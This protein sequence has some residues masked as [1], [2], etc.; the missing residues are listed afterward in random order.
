MYWHLPW[1]HWA[2]DILCIHKHD[3][4]LGLNSLIEVMVTNDWSWAIHW[5]VSASSPTTLL[6]CADIRND[7]LLPLCKKIKTAESSRRT[8]KI[9]PF[10]ANIRK[11]CQ[12]FCVVHCIVSI[13]HG[14]GYWFILDTLHLRASGRMSYWHMSHYWHHISLNWLTLSH[15]IVWNLTSMMWSCSTRLRYIHKQALEHLT[16]LANFIWVNVK[17]HDAIGLDIDL[18]PQDISGIVKQYVT[19]TLI[20]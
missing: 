10:L 12:H 6:Y 11:I 7:V 19:E 20:S 16:L 9:M 15:S 2:D 4:F 3:T 13:E 18:H 14:S 1:D 17:S 5:Y 8:P